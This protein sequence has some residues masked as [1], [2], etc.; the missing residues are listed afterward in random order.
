VV[1]RLFNTIGPRQTGQYGMVVP[2]FVRRALLGE[3]IPVFGDGTQRRSF[4]WVGDVTGAMIK[5]IERPDAYGEVFN[6]GHTKDVS[7]YD[8]AVLIKRLTG[9]RSDIVRVPYREAYES[10]FEDMARRLPDIS[11][12]QQRIGYAPTMDLTEMLTRIIK[13]ERERLVAE[14]LMSAEAA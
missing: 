9:S 10:G 8:L 14:G 12:L 5:L 2:R 11:K 1:V 6:I 13:A 7:I 3:P 4:T